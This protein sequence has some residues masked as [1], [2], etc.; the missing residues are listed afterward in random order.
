MARSQ[1]WSPHIS[2]LP[3]P[4]SAV[5]SG[6]KTAIRRPLNTSLT[7]SSTFPGHLAADSDQINPGMTRNSLGQHLFRSNSP[8]VFTPQ[9]GPSCVTDV[10]PYWCANMFCEK[11]CN[12]YVYKTCDGWKRHMKEH[13][14]IWP[15]MPHGPLEPAGVNLICA[16]CDSINPNESHMDGHSIGD[17]GNISTKVRGVSRR[18]NLERHLLQSHAVSDHCT[19]HLADKWKTTLRKKH[20][21][22]GF[23]VSIFSTILEQLNHIDMNHFRRGQ[24][25][26]E[27]SAT[28]VIRGLLLPPKVAS[29]FQHLLFSDP[30]AVDRDLHWDRD[31]IEDLQRRLEMAEDPAETLAF[32]AYWMLTSNLSRQ[33]PDGQHPAM[34]LS[35]LNLVGQ[36]ELAMGSFAVSADTLE[37]DIEHQK[38][39]FA[40]GSRSLKFPYE[41]PFAAPTATYS[42]P[43]SGLPVRQRD[44]PETRIGMEQRTAYH[45]APRESSI[46]S[47]SCAPQSQSDLFP[48]QIGSASIITGLNPTLAHDSSGT[49]TYWQAAPSTTPSNLHSTE[50]ADM[51]RE[52]LIIRQGPNHSMKVAGTLTS[53]PRDFAQLSSLEWDPFTCD[54]CDPRDLIMKLE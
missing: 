49:S 8:Q 52:Q 16:I 31:R 44:T 22:C 27:W 38:A 47:A 13:E 54:T 19:R 23:C 4:Q 17:C 1:P 2:G 5:T 24:Q 46:I 34:N 48:V 10:Q 35:G 42:R 30:D 36:S 51:L 11:H 32:D 37:S 6:S 41:Y 21:S 20:F 3:I 45:V 26:T 28:K 15:C 25:I 40:Q 12:R 18:V 39:E 53:D 50:A 29:S 9:A 14:T 43:E 33:N 7:P